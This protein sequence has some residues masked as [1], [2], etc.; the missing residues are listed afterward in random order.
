MQIY[1]M[2]QMFKLNIIR[3]IREK[4]VQFVFR[5]KIKPS[6]TYSQT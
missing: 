4:F 5:Y 1:Q 6:Q 3:A 2:T